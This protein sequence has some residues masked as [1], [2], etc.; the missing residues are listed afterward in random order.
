MIPRGDDIFYRLT[1]PISRCVQN[2]LF[3]KAFGDGR[4]PMCRTEGGE[5]LNGGFFLSIYDNRIYILFSP[6]DISLTVFARESARKI[7]DPLQVHNN[8]IIVQIIQLLQSA[9]HQHEPFNTTWPPSVY[10][11]FNFVSLLF[12]SFFSLTLFQ[13]IAVYDTVLV[14]SLR[15]V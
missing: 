5:F 6:A 15:S 11:Y 8:I 1:K 12:F 4:I 10:N 2:I 13:Y 3:K 7:N 9:G 14:N